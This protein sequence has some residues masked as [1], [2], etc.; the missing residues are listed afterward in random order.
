MGYDAYTFN[1]SG[2][3]DTTGANNFVRSYIYHKE[4]LSETN[5]NMHWW[6]GCD[7]K[8]NYTTNAKFTMTTTGTNASN[9]SIT[10]DNQKWKGG[11]HPMIKD[12]DYNWARTTTSYTVKVTATLKPYGKS[13]GTA[14]V[15][16][17]VP[18]LK[19]YTLKFNSN[20]GT[21]YNDMTKFYNTTIQLP[22]T[23]RKTG[24]EFQGWA[25]SNGGAVVYRGGANYTIT[26]DATLYA[27]WKV[28]YIAP[29]IQ[30]NVI[31]YRVS[32][33]T[34]S[35]PKE[36]S[37]G[38][39]AYV[40]FTT[41][42]GTNVN[43]DNSADIIYTASYTVNGGTS[44]NFSL[45]RKQNTYTYSGIIG[46]DGD[47]D[48]GTAYNIQ[49]QVTN[50]S[51]SDTGAVDLITT[52]TFT[53]P[54]QVYAIDIAADSRRVAF[55]GVASDSPD[56]NTRS[57]FGIEVY[58]HVAF[59]KD[60]SS[61]NNF[62]LWSSPFNNW[63]LKIDDTDTYIYDKGASTTTTNNKLRNMSS[64]ITTPTITKN[65]TN[66]GNCDISYVR[67]IKWGAIVQLQFIITGNTATA[68]SSNFFVGMLPDGYKPAAYVSGVGFYG[69]RAI[70][71]RIT[72]DGELMV[73]NTHSESV[74]PTEGIDFGLTYI[75]Q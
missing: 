18:A 14:T 35:I 5:L 54:K 72:T 8:A 74:T 4:E 39:M 66:G 22:S 32:P 51:T 21:T 63:A 31:G 57:D 49:V 43:Y 62:G 12:V 55:G 40:E 34:A 28:T 46:S 26:K 69:A 16:L 33:D 59:K 23:P 42:S 70:V 30:G 41:N 3:L 37:N 1:Y 19:Q 7:V 73:R 24:Y 50:K 60:S 13:A 61:S 20:G 17:T 38:T 2:W 67:A 45:T 44:K 29:I 65:S 25:T 71:C 48:V 6:A 75:V 9:R 53:L 15:S 64:I 36:D 11:A 56:G 47:F 52:A 10:L 27:V 68:S 58:G